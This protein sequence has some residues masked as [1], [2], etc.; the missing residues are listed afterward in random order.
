[1]SQPQNTTPNE[2]SLSGHFLI[3]MP[4]MLDPSFAGSVVYL[5]EHSSKGAM[6]LVINRPTDL[7]I[8]ALLEK[9]ELEVEGDLPQHFPV[10]AGGPVAAERGFV[11]HTAPLQWNSSLPVNDRISLTT[12]KDILEAVAKGQAPSQWLITL[13]Y[14]GWGEGQLEQELAQNAWLTVPANDD[15]LFNTP[16][17]ER[18][19]SAYGLLGIDPSL[20]TG[21]AGHA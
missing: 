2:F 15:I 20:L 7:D 6:G 1:M 17:E 8:V 16:L 19:A 9:I 18:F 3:A 10:M 13:G 12:S 11:L 5:C 21:A 4:N 14:A